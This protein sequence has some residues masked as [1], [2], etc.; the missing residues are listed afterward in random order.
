MCPWHNRSILNFKHWYYIY[1]IYNIYVLIKITCITFAS[2][3]HISNGFLCCGKYICTVPICVY[4]ICRCI[5]TSESSIIVYDTYIYGS[6]I[7]RATTIIF[8]LVEIAIWLK[9]LNEFFLFLFLFGLVLFVWRY[10]MQRECLSVLLY[11]LWDCWEH[12]YIKI[13]IYKYRFLIRFLRWSKRMPILK[14]TIFPLMNTI[15]ITCIYAT[16][17]SKLNIH[18]NLIKNYVYKAIKQSL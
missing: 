4:N 5:S 8:P 16:I 15:D 14:F 13:S 12:K 17:D 2:I 3:V 11:H 6:I 7:E 10:P 18:L 1:I 9:E